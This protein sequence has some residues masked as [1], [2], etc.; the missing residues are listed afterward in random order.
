MGG[1]EKLGKVGGEREGGRGSAGRK[2][3]DVGVGGM[4]EGTEGGGNRE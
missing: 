2:G 3:G 1:G 4:I